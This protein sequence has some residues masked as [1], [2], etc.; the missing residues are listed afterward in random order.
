M[1]LL[2]TGY[3]T[4]ICIYKFRKTYATFLEIPITWSLFLKNE[5]YAVI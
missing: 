5:Y 4:I 1:T 3:N 2:I